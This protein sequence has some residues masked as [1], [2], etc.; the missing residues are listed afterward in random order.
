MAV[1]FNFI[2]CIFGIKKYNKIKPL[3]IPDHIHKTIKQTKILLLEYE[4]FINDLFPIIGD[5]TFILQSSAYHTRNSYIA[6]INALIN[7]LEV[8]FHLFDNINTI[9]LSNNYI[10]SFSRKLK[11]I[12]TIFKTNIRL[13]NDLDSLTIEH[14]LTYSKSFLDI[15]DR[16]KKPHFVNIV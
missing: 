14:S 8:D 6:K 7:K 16:S 10:M 3:V 5:L 4:R 2:F 12:D 1:L 9:E 13:L 15:F 11:D